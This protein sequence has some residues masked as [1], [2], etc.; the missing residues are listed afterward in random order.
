MTSERK[1]QLTLLALSYAYANLDDVIEATQ[2]FREKTLIEEPINGKVCC[3]SEIVDAPT[4]Q[5]MLELMESF[6]T[7]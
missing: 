5:E 4:F 3:Q 6:Q 7:T 2:A 1:R